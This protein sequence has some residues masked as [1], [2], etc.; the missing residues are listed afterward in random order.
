MLLGMLTNDLSQ[1]ALR[2]RTF[3]AALALLAPA[4]AQTSA[5]ARAQSPKVPAWTTIQTLPAA[6]A[7][8]AAAADEQFL[9]AISSTQVAKYDRRSGERLAI[10]RGD[11]QHLNSGFFRDNKLYCAHSNYPRLP[12]RSEIKVLDTRTMELTTF[13]DFGNFGGSLTWAV[14]R[15][16]HWWCN[17]ARY[18]DDNAGTFLVKFTPAWQEAGRWMYPRDLIGQLGRYSLSGGVWQQDE[19]LVTGHDDPVLF[20]LRLPE[21]GTTLQLLGTETVP[22]TGQGIAHDPVTGGLAGIHRRRRELI[23]ATRQ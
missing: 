19:L 11:A 14:Y 4:A 5:T 22:F 15:D 7:H 6:E 3:L 12:E 23:I 16:G 21:E 17:F 10:S 20:R 13:R 18:G 8:Q 1:R 9:Y 2:R